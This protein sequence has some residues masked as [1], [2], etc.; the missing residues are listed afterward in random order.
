M[1]RVHVTEEKQLYFPENPVTEARQLLKKLSPRST[2]CNSP[3]GEKKTEM[4][5]IYRKNS[6][7]TV[8]QGHSSDTYEHTS[9]SA[10]LS[11][12]SNY[13]NPEPKSCKNCWVNSLLQRLS[14]KTLSYFL[15]EQEDTLGRRG[16][17]PFYITQP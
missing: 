13:N 9:R 4:K 12:T 17:I 11:I 10:V 5:P 3:S 7:N 8:K 2:L 16:E 15:N 6:R 14:F 1:E